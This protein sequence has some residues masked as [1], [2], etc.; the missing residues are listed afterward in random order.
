MN[1]ITV[2]HP[3]RCGMGQSNAKIEFKILPSIE[4]CIS[5]YYSLQL[6]FAL[7]LFENRLNCSSFHNVSCE[8]RMGQP[9]PLP[10]ILSDQLTLN[11]KL[12]RHK[13]F[14]RIGFPGHELCKVLL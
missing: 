1:D 12:A 6:G 3:M 11:L 14:L 10:S 4:L 13:Q 2:L 9:S 8:R 7:D 5:C